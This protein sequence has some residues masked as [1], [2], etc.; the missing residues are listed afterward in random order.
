MTSRSEIER[1]LDRYLAEGAEQVPDRVIDDALD[2]IDHTSQRRV[3]GAPWRFQAMPSFLK[4]ALA[5]AA[6]IAV[7]VVGG[8]LL[9][10]GPTDNLG[11]QPSAT[12]SPSVSTSVDAPSP[13]PAL[14]DTRNWVSFTSERYGYAIGH[15]PSWTPTAAV[16]DWEF[17]T[18]QPDHL[19]A[20]ADHFIDRGAAY[21][22][23]V[24]AFATDVATGM[25]EDEWIADFYEG[26]PASCSL[27]NK[28][29]KAVS[30]D[31]HAGMLFIDDNCSDSQ[32]FVLV[33]GRIHVFAIW[34]ANR[35]ALLE[36]F[37]STVSFQP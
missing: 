11:G 19:T 33:D 23:L 21:Q 4:P 32:A 2:E 3:M 18:D 8:V 13:T 27:E 29:R 37:L 30:V 35:E 26:D 6:V 7:V 25:S 36:S 15:P 34:R 22:I 9:T 1:T 5:G 16:R 10:R 14:T 28:E 24:T 17:E 31:G 12:P 20:A